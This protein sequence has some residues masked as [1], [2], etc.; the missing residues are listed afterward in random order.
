MIY[1]N[2]FL[3]DRNRKSKKKKLQQTNPKIDDLC[4]KV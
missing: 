3:S 1:A 2:T 4:P